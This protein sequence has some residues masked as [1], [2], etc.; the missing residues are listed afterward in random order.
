MSSPAPVPA[1]WNKLV[2][3]VERTFPKQRFKVKETQSGEAIWNLWLSGGDT[4]LAYLSIMGR[5]PSRRRFEFVTYGDSGSSSRTKIRTKYGEPAPSFRDMKKVLE[6]TLKDSPN[7]VAKLRAKGITEGQKDLLGAALA[8]A[9]QVVK[10]T[11]KVRLKKHVWGD[12]ES[13]EGT[14][15]LEY[16]SGQYTEKIPL[17]VTANVKTKT[18]TIESFDQKVEYPTIRGL[19]GGLTRFQRIFAKGMRSLDFVE[20][21]WILGSLTSE[22]VVRRVVSVTVDFEG[23]DEWLDTTV[24]AV[25]MLTTK[26]NVPETLLREWVQ[27]HWADIMAKAPKSKPPTPNPD[28]QRGRTDEWDEPSPGL[29][30]PDL[31]DVNIRDAEISVEQ[32]GNQARAWINYAVR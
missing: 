13:G 30:H 24:N 10:G 1:D 15:R 17:Q 18:F 26:Y 5:E 23:V 28:R 3:W 22:D 29:K 4:S 19:L 16:S 32:D 21:K 7:M 20:K 25:L 14:L 9:Q 6:A 31:S 2:Q 8:V 27:N 12:P 11:L